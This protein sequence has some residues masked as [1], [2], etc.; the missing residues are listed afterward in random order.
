M[1]ERCAECG[2]PIEPGTG[3]ARQGDEGVEYICEECLWAS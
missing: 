1:S 2:T 3:G